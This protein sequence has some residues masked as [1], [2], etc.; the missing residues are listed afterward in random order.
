MG[1]YHKQ[2]VEDLLSLEPLLANNPNAP[3]NFI[4][5]GV[6]DPSYVPPYQGGVLL[7]VVVVTMI[8]VYSVVGLRL[9]VRKGSVGIRAD[10]WLVLAATVSCTSSPS[11]HISFFLVL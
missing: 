3:T 4:P 8:V 2:T 6:V 10:D 7:I 9:W 5:P 11:L 1:I